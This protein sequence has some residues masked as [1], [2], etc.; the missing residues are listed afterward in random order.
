MPLI[1]LSESFCAITGIK[2]VT[3]AI[4]PK[5]AAITGKRDT[6]PF[7]FLFLDFAIEPPTKGLISSVC[8]ALRFVY[9][10]YYINYRFVKAFL[11]KIR[12]P[13]EI[14]EY[15]EEAAQSL[16]N[17]QR[18]FINALQSHLHFFCDKFFSV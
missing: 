10:L 3:I 8:S 17:D 1:V 9:L 18:A 12:Y 13:A 14:T 15:T 11:E 4:N 6:T 2:I 5:N 16:F 7:A